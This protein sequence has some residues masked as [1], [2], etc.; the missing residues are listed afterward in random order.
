MIKLCTLNDKAKEFSQWVHFNIFRLKRQYISPSFTPPPPP[1]SF[2]PPPPTKK[3]D[4]RKTESQGAEDIQ[5]LLNEADYHLKNS[6]EISEGVGALAD[7][8]LRDLHN[9][10]DDTKDEFNNCFIIHSK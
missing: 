5:E 8:T 2:R 6:V 4:T 10:S 9:S 1:P 3:R 7:N